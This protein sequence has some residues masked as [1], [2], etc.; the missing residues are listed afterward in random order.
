LLFCGEPLFLCEHDAADPK[1]F[2]RVEMNGMHE[3]SP[4]PRACRYGEI[5][6]GMKET[7]DYVITPDVYDHFLAAFQDRNPVHVDDAYARSQGFTGKVMH[8]SI[9]NGFVSHF[10]GMHFPGKWSLLLSVDLRFSNPSGL[11]DSIRMEV[12]VTQK[13]DARN[14]VVLD[15]TLS[16]TTRGCVAAR[17]RIQ[18]MI[19]EAP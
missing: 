6:V 2:F 5:S 14:V 3:P 15:A 12:E 19:K 9:L 13:V 18:V 17:G 7:R 8:G 16:N 10:I 11:G 1:D 4:T